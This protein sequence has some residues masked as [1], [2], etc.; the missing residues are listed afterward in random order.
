LHYNNNLNGILPLLGVSAIKNEKTLFVQHNVLLINLF[1]LKNHI[2]WQYALLSSISGVDYLYSKYRFC[3]VYD[4]LSLRTNSRLRIKT[5]IN[6]ITSVESSVNIFINANWWEREVWDLFGIYFKN[7]LDLRRLLTD[8]G[9]EGFPMRKDYPLAGFI[10]LRYDLTK[11]RIVVEPSVLAQ[12]F[13]FF[14]F[15]TPW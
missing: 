8:Y 2:S 11:K 1:S 5:F 3:V 6:E 13:R 4:L 7:H 15:E 14:S 9:F 10:E 12:D